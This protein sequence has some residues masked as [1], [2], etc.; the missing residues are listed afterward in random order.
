MK[1]VLFRADAKP[2]I[3]IGDLMSLIHL[4][5]YFEGDGWSTYF[6]IRSYPAALKL[7][8]KY[9]VKNLKIIESDICIPDEV[10]AINQYVREKDIDLVFFEITE[11]RLSDYTGITS[12]VY[13]ACVSFDGHI[14]PDMDLV[15]DWD[16]EAEKIIQPA[17]YP[18]TK[19]LL[20]PEFVILPFNF[21]KNRIN[22]RIYNK[23][24]Q[25]LLICMGGADEHNIT[26]KIVKT[27][28]E[29]KNSLHTTIVIG[30]GYEHREKLESCI[31]K[32]FFNCEI[33]ENISNMF[34]EYMACDVAIGAG[35]LT[36]SEL[37]ATNTPAFLIGVYIHQEARCRYFNEKGWAIYLGD[38]YEWYSN[39]PK[40]LD[41]KVTN[42][43]S[44]YFNTLSIVKACNGFNERKR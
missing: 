39:F 43:A 28:I 6:M 5:K 13:K 7:V 8:D 18:F 38:R 17:R 30:S 10:F 36:A 26:C 27:L 16:V 21:D 40:I 44:T 9:G 41:C 29:K 3:G 34:E 37:V 4:A 19:F 2:E 15:V 20:G 22:R 23:L 14:L 32:G 25:R 1:K 12:N 35:G 42:K 11:N 24:P 33:K 31:R